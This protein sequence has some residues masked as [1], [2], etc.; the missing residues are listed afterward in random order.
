MLEP[1][2]TLVGK[3]IFQ[4]RLYLPIY[5]VLQTLKTLRQVE[6][7]N[8]GDCL[9]RSKGAVAI[10]DAVKEGLHKLKVL[11]SSCSLLNLKNPSLQFP[12]F[13]SILP[14][15]QSGIHFSAGS[16]LPT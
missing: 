3:V 12:P 10:A 16:V 6:V 8:F 13:L 15:I 5:A 9:V 4:A 1:C 2:A 7:I 11:L 14:L